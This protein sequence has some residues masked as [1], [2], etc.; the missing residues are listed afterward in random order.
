M[1]EPKAEAFFAS[2]S[3]VCVYVDVRGRAVRVQFESAIG[4]GIAQETDG[5]R[6]AEALAVAG[7]ALER[8]RVHLQPL[9][10]KVASELAARR[11]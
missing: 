5:S 9:F 2:A 7:S 1:I 3:G 10:D 4:P 11:G 8:H 6:A